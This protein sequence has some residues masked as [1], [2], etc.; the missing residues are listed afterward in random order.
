[1]PVLFLVGSV[2]VL[3]ALS[4]K[5]TA[6]TKVAPPVSIPP[7]YAPSPG[8]SAPYV[9]PSTPIGYTPPPPLTA[10]APST[11][12]VLLPATPSRPFPIYVTR[13]EAEREA[14]REAAARRREF[15]ADPT[16][17][18][19]LREHGDTYCDGYIPM[20]PLDEST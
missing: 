15:C 17:R 4:Q 9:P 2:L 18:R 6:P 11:P 12:M 1:M 19:R 13:E 5:K 20:F 8:Y 7:G 14:A 10:P 3:L 16:N